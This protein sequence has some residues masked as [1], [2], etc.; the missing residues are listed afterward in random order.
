MSKRLPTLGLA[1]SL[2][3]IGFNGARA[4]DG[5]KEKVT[6]EEITKLVEQLG[7]AGKDD[8]T[9]AEK[10]LREIGPAALAALRQ[11]LFQT[12]DKAL[13]RAARD[14]VGQIGHKVQKALEA[15]LAKRKAKDCTIRR[16][17]DDAVAQAFPG[18]LV[19]AVS[20]RL[21]PVA[22]RPPAPLRVQNLF[23]V[24]K[25]EEQEHITD[26]QG[27]QTFFKENL[28]QVLTEDKAKKAARAWLEMSQVLAQDGYYKF[29]ISNKDLTAG[30]AKTGVQATGKAVVKPE[31]GNQGQIQVTIQFGLTGELESVKEKK[32]L[33]R[34]KRPR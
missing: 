24:G 31:N 32:D 28:G 23:I 20:F 11:T 18:R 22:V 19:L 33:V 4:A 21:Y 25:D 9:R 34:G 29:S 27:L 6:A 16:L 5:A 12:K 3:L 7:A 10:R 8:R 30:P 13:A 1:C 17:Q 26:F 14:V 15:R 2:L